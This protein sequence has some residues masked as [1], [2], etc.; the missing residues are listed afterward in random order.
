VVCSERKAAR[1]RSV[2][3]HHEAR[4]ADCLSAFI[5]TRLCALEVAEHLTWTSRHRRF[6]DLSTFNRMLA[7]NE[8]IAHLDLLLARGS[9]TVDTDDGLVVY[10]E[11]EPNAD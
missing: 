4:L 1:V 2:A 11:V 3:R 10:T 8:T 7:V 6:S 9:L 5:G